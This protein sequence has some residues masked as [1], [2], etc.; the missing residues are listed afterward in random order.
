MGKHYTIVESVGRHFEHVHDYKDLEKHHPTQP[1]NPRR[2]HYGDIDGRR[3]EFVYAPSGERMV[4]KDFVLLENGI[5][6]V[7]IPSPLTGYARR[8]ERLDRWGTVEIYDGLGNG[9]RL[10]GRVRHMEPI[11]VANGE[12]VECGQPLGRQSNKSPPAIR[13]GLHTYGYQ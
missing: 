1:E 11:L 5:A 2:R 8:S 13:I 4:S 12:R 10:I 6:H 9:A 3:E 7:V